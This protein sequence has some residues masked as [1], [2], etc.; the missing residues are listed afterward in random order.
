M[1][2][3][4]L[5]PVLILAVLTWGCS[6]GG[7]SGTYVRPA[8]ECKCAQAMGGKCKCNHCA[9]EAGAKC[10]CGQGGCECGAKMPRCQCGHC[11]GKEGGDDGKGNCKCSESERK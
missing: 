10:Y 5:I 1:R 2:W 3:M 8:E 11:V 6:Y 4:E 9:G 7:G